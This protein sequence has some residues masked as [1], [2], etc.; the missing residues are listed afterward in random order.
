MDLLHKI[1]HCPNILQCFTSQDSNACCKIISTQHSSTLDQHQVPE[2]WNGDIEHAPIL[3][4]G[5]NP[6]IDKDEVFPLWSWQGEAIEDFFA[7][8]LEHGTYTLLQNGSRKHVTFWTSVHKRAQELLG[9][10]VHGGV[11]Y[12]LTEVV[13]CKSKTEK[14]IKKKTLD[15]CVKRYL[16]PV[17]ELSG[18]K[19]IVVLGSKARKAVEN[20]LKNELKNEFRLSNGRAFG[21]LQSGEHQRYIAFLPHPNA[22][23]SRTFEKCLDEKTLQKLRAF[24][25]T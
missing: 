7:H 14:D 6:A 22:H 23:E 25:N 10:D 16:Q 5:P 17:L 19:V 13:H 15:E 11:D 21:P 2:P 18:A 9:D 12:A 4:L 3:F 8:R 24:L 20:E 1:A